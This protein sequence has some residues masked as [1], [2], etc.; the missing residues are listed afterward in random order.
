VRASLSL[1][2]VSI[3][4]SAAAQPSP[5]PEPKKTP[6]ADVKALNQHGIELLDQK[7]YD[8]ALA[9]FKEAYAR[10]KSAK[11]LLNLGTTLNLLNRKAEA[12]NE[13]QRYLDASDSDP[14]RHGE[15]KSVLADLDKSV[16]RLRID[17][18]PADAEVQ[19]EVAKAM[20]AT[21]EWH[22]R[23]EVVLWR[24]E[25]GDI[26]VRARREG[27]QPGAQ[28]T[29]V[30]AGHEAAVRVALVAVPKQGPI[31]VE[32]PVQHEGPRARFG[33]RATMHASVYPRIGSAVLVGATMD[34]TRQ[35]EI[36]AGMLLGP[37][38]VSSA[39]S[40]MYAIQPPWIGAYVGATFAFLTGRW[41]PIVSG[42]IP[43]FI[44]KDATMQNQ[45]RFALRLAGGVEWVATRQLALT[46]ELGFESNL[47]PDSDIKS[48]AIVPAL[49]VA[50]RL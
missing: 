30:A 21:D 35:L 3:A 15:V 41:R 23:A 37:G 1:A 4:A 49:G 28:T 10:F 16:G 33:A 50:G 29:T 25:P 12:A 31:V 36:D 45:A 42:E 48:I 22:P 26:T 40:N 44:E 27:Y 13:Y 9:V 20:I 2:I 7:Q 18:S 32:A 47:A 39:S 19:V 11:I 8:Q 34:A 14:S 46:L 24:V 17:V 5:Q 6:T 43:L 38:L